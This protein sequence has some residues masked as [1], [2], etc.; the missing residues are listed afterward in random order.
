M[1]RQ[2][3]K[4]GETDWKDCDTAWFDYCRYTAEFD[5][6]SIPDK[7]PS[8]L[9]LCNDVLEFELVDN[10]LM[11]VNIH[12]YYEE[13]IDTAFRIIDKYDAK[14]IIEHLQREFKL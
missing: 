1:Q 14:L 6:R 8:E 12:P 5:T 11:H 13:D 4:I 9:L 3:R 7:V 2:W 10:D